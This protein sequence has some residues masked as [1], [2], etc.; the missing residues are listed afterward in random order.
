MPT[1]QEIIFDCIFEWGLVLDNIDSVSNG[2]AA[3]NRKLRCVS[4]S[5]PPIREWRT[6][7]DGVQDLRSGLEW[8]HCVN[9]I[10]GTN[11][12]LGSGVPVIWVNALSVCHNRGDGWRLPNANEALSLYDYNLQD[13]GLDPTYFPNSPN[14]NTPF[15]TSTTSPASNPNFTDAILIH[16]DGIS[17]VAAKTSSHYVRCVRTSND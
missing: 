3:D 2:A 10:T 11:C 9:G 16:S 4:G 7:P 12:E 13:P 5:N 14:S 6:T 17:S 15:W 8:D 1:K